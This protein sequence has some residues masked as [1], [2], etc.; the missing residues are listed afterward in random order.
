MTE[1]TTKPTR[2]EVPALLIEATP[3]VNGLGYWLLASPLILYL[4]WLWVDIFAYYSP[5]PWRWLD[6]IVGALVYWFLFVLPAGY[7]MHR[8]VT[9]F[10][11]PFQHTGWDV[12]PLEAVRPAEMYAV[13]YI[14]TGRQPAPR[15]RQRVG[16]RAAQGW[17]YL[18][19][20]TIFVGAVLMIPLF[21]SA[22]DFGFGR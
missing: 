5:I 8:L 21:F 14:F 6:L 7:A 22:L 3:P 2:R 16:L 19:V 11:R 12:Q 9:A 10:P 17:V 15:D 13:R 1:P 20:A 18:E 4:G